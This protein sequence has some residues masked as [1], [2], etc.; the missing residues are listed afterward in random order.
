[1]IIWG[2]SR[3]KREGGVVVDWIKSQVEKDK[4]YEIEFVDLKELKL[5]IFDEVCN[6]FEMTSFD[7]YE[8]PE[9]KAWAER[10]N[11]AEAFLIIT[12]EYN[13]SLPGVLKNAL[14]TVGKPWIDKPVGIISYGGL[15]G[16]MIAASHLRLIATELGLLQTSNW[17]AFPYFKKSFDSKGQPERLDYYEAMVKKMLDGI[18]R[19]HQ[20][21]SPDRDT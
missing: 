20:K 10:V 1:M 7:A 19:I 17:L 8:N 12:P 16:G 21:F 3:Q 18:D 13:R 15:S 5:P 14:D 4:R 6:P 2:S 11:V 9:S